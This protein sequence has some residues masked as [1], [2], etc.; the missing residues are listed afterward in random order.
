L[1]HLARELSSLEELA[2]A[3]ISFAEDAQRTAE[4]ECSALEDECRGLRVALEGERELNRQL[5][6]EN[7]ELGEALCPSS[8]LPPMNATASNQGSAQRPFNAV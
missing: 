5:R 2:Q 8:S 7:A 6:E 1:D 3:D 4:K